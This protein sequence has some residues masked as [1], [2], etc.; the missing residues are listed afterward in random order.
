MIIVFDKENII[1]L[2]GRAE[3]DNLFERVLGFLKRQSSIHFN[4]K[5]NVLDEYEEIILEE[6]FDGVSKEFTFNYGEDMIIQRNPLKDNSFPNYNNVYLLNDDSVKK[7]QE[8][9]NLLIG[10]VGEEIETLDKLI[11]DNEDYGYHDQLVIPESKGNFWEKVNSLCVPFTRLIIVDRYMFKPPE[12]GGN[13]G[14]FENN[15]GELL[16]NLY[17]NKTGFSKIV[18]IYQVNPY[19]SSIGHPDYDEG[20]DLLKTKQKIKAIIKKAN[21]NCKTPEISLIGV[22]KGRIKDEHDRHIIMNYIRIK[23]GD[24]F[25]YFLSEGKKKTRSN[26][27]DVYSMGKR[28]YRNTTKS[29]VNSIEN[30]V[31]QT[32]E[33]EHTYCDCNNDHRFN[34]LI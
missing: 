3:R 7:I 30:F 28:K 24:C 19:S 22:P 15:V 12:V 34:D 17:K 2:I 20:P 1:S 21:K 6:F 8:K 29:L 32:I 11:I 18:F 13:Y 25:T 33:Q 26:E 5:K 31:N 10:N 14:L 9:H 16:T 27:L 23:S 4:F